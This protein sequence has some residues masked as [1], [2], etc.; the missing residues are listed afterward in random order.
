M[1]R[2]KCALASIALAGG[3]SVATSA[4]A[5]DSVEAFYRGKTI[6]LLIGADVGGGYDAY[7]RLVGRHISKYIPG[8][9]AIVPSN[10]AGAGGNA[11]LNYLYAVAPRD[12]AALAA[13][14]PGALLDP[15]L[16]EKTTLRHDPLKFNYIGSATGEVFTCMVRTDAAA[17]SF[18]D[19]FSKEVIIGSSGGTTHDMPRALVNVLG[20]KF[21]LISG[22]RGTLDVALA[23]ERGEVQGLCG[24]GYANIS[25]QRP[26][27]I[28]AGSPVRVLAQESITG[29]PELNKRGVPLTLDFA[30]TPEQRQILEIIYAQGVF[31]RPFVM[32]P[33]V[34]EE[35]VAAI[36]TA[37]MQALADPELLADAQKQ[38]LNVIPLAGVDLDRMI[39]KIHAT[40][41]DIVEK[42]RRAIVDQ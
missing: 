17:K 15:L 42:V 18:E 2:H 28:R 9:P 11:V 27:W 3:L 14:A 38:S 40:P 32:A 13:S 1:S 37:F 31:T 23:V 36:R 4:A 29:D 16:G 5:Q 33:D 22:Y 30:K 41:P 10:M 35:R 34:P 25:W 26:D 19:A 12:G 7:A 20:V 24:Q 8:R 21:K 39:R 6:R